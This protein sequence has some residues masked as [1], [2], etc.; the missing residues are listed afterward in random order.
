MNLKSIYP[1]LFFGI[2]TSNCSGNNNGINKTK[3]IVAT[4]DDSSAK[5]VVKIIGVG[6]MMLGTNYPSADLLPPNDGKDILTPVKDI[7]SRGDV[8]FGNLEGVILTGSG[9][10]KNCS[11]PK[12]CYTFKMPD[13]YINYIKDAGFNLLS[14]ANNHVQDFGSVGTANT[15][16]ILQQADIPHAGLEICP[17]T[18]FQK[19]GLTYGFAA[20]APNPGTVNINDYSRAEKIIKYLDSFCD[21]VIVSFH[22]GGEGSSRSH[23]TRTKEIF[24]GENRG[25]PYEFARV[26]IDAGADIVFGHGPH[27]TRAVDVYKDRFIAYSMGNFA[28]Y[29]MFNLAG[30][31]GIAP[32]VE[33]DVDAKGK[34]LKGKIYST[35][36]PGQGGPVMDE[37]NGALKEIIKLTAS[38]IPECTLSITDNGDIIPGK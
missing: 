15:H 8:S 12:F 11:N 21:I 18:T 36:Q 28:T 17:Y 20:F 5:K 33:L 19:N 22:G 25:N 23:I 24:L 7:I 34:F 2:I 16:K 30:I 14:V 31:S 27:V 37:N 32:I 9:P 38:D 3:S 13:H 10:A 4:G 6:D 29:G 35:K 26:V 1:I